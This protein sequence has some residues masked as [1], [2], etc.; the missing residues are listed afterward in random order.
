M[1]I[2]LLKHIG[3]KISSRIKRGGIIINNHNQNTRQ[4]RLQVETLGRYF[5]FIHHNELLQ[6]LT[7]R[8]SKP[9]CLFT[10]DDG[11]KINA[12]EA[13]P[14]LERLG[15]PAVFYVVTE[16][17]HQNQLLW[18][19]LYQ[20]LLKKIKVLPPDMELENLKQMPYA[21]LKERLNKLC[22]HYKIAVDISDPTIR[23]MS[24]NDIRTLHSKGFTIGAHSKWHSILTNESF[25]VAIDDI[26][27]SIDTVSKETGSNCLSFAFPNGNYTKKLAQYVQ[28]FGVET[29]MTTDP[30]WANPSFQTW[31]LPRIQLYNSYNS[32]LIALKIISAL[33][34]F[35][36]KNP[37][38]TGRTYIW[39][40]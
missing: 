23:P 11:Q 20:E 37:N 36:L 7:Q 10:F 35:L 31:K 28:S 5:D 21:I 19:N 4:I 6:R 34:G 1:I 38:G 39:G 22:K 27:Y 2:S 29:V 30:V 3:L 13:A 25:K 15:V 14:E 17:S 32:N 8:R 18:F 33:P 26:K 12:T 16:F 9:F 24:W 40:K